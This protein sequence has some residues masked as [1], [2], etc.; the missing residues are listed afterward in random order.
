MKTKDDSPRRDKTQ[1][2]HNTLNQ[3]KTKNEHN[4]LNQ[5]KTQNDDNED[6]TETLEVS[7]KVG[8]SFSME[9]GRALI[10]LEN[11]GKNR[12]T[13][14]DISLSACVFVL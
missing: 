12:G 5:H 1:N 2:Q 3:Y 8:T 6:K 10:A 11:V 4:K 14:D 13:K 9:K 7:R